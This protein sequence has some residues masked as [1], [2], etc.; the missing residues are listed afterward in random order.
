MV[1]IVKKTFSENVS[2]CVGLQAVNGHAAN[3]MVG[4]NAFLISALSANG[5]IE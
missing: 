5:Q 1:H 3:S 2:Q 4:R